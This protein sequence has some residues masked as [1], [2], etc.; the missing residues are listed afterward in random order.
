MLSTGEPTVFMVEEARRSCL[1]DAAKLHPV[2]V[3]GSSYVD[4]VE[5]AQI[6]IQVW[7]TLVPIGKELVMFINVYSRN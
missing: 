1:L 7:V 5:F 2:M 6:I 3:T 4:C